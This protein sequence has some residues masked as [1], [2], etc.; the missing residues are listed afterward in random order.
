MAVCLVHIHGRCASQP[1]MS[2]RILRFSDSSTTQR[3]N[4]RGLAYGRTCGA[5]AN[6]EAKLVPSRR[7]EKPHCS[8]VLWR[9]SRSQLE[10]HASAQCKHSLT[11]SM[12]LQ[13]TSAPTLASGDLNLVV[14]PSARTDLASHPLVAG[15]TDEHS[16]K[17]RKGAIVTPRFRAREAGRRVRGCITNFRSTPRTPRG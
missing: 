8:S 15:N 10:F 12:P 9:H 13:I 7:N 16:R 2:N 3:C 11:D 1:P 6:I 17:L 14:A 5:T 4:Q